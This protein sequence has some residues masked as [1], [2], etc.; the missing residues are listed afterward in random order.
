MEN[1]NIVVNE[2]QPKK[3][4]ISKVSTLVENETEKLSNIEKSPKIT[5]Q[6]ANILASIYSLNGII[7]S[8]LGISDRSSWVIHKLQKEKLNDADLYKLISTLNNRDPFR[9]QT[10]YKS[11]ID[12]AM[13]QNSTFITLPEKRANEL[14]NIGDLHHDIINM[15]VELFIK[16]T[17]DK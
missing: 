4:R 7:I 11:T 5:G 15:E 17:V 16:L 13:N 8:I 14:I 12:E 3:S 1:E 10:E 9:K 2:E 6:K